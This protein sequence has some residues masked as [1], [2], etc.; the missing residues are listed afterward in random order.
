MQP[1]G[2]KFLQCL[3]AVLILACTV[4]WSYQKSIRV[5][6]GKV[7][8]S[9]KPDLNK[10]V[11]LISKLS[12]KISDEQST[13]DLTFRKFPVR[14]AEKKGKFLGKSMVR[15]C[16]RSLQVLHSHE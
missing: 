9:T 4:S 3:L 8:S 13:E 12:K 1:K 6:R 11:D 15:N 10:I 7:S 14:F 2:I 5:T 16:G